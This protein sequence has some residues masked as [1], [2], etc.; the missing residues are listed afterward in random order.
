MWLG[1]VF[2]VIWTM[3]RGGGEA[4][5]ALRVVA[6]AGA[7]MLALVVG[8]ACVVG[9]LSM[10]GCSMLD[11][12][13]PV[14]AEVRAEI[15]GLPERVTGDELPKLLARYEAAVKAKAAKAA[16]AAAAKAAEITRAADGKAKAAREADA[17][18]AEKITAQ[19]REQAEAVKRARA[20]HAAALGKAESD[21]AEALQ[22]I[23]TDFSAAIASVAAA[24]QRAAE[25]VADAL[26]QSREEAG[27][28]LAEG[29]AAAQKIDAD[30]KA[31]A[32][33]AVDA[34]AAA[35]QD[36]AERW[37]IASEIAGTGSSLLPI[38]LGSVPGVG[39]IAIALQ[40][41]LAR[42]RDAAEKKLSQEQLAKV[43][44]REALTRDTL[45]SVV[46]AV[47]FVS[48]AAREA[49]KAKAREQMTEPEKALVK[50]VRRETDL[51][52]DALRARDAA[53]VP[54]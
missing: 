18:L 33:G 12:R 13:V 54:A 11:D 39:G 42:R 45:A 30:G 29:A 47:E 8:L 49:V 28:V 52:V 34:L 16:E 1:K 51:D 46:A 37:G 26:A 25:D 19:Q 23:E 27:R 2:A 44:E 38:L 3:R 20:A 22:G 4:R 6:W 7:M 9:V 24:R 15:P 50:E 48:P 41:W 35:R 17:A 43:Q 10:G 31:V 21:L 5:S 32:A 53:A 40:Q 14:P 36:A